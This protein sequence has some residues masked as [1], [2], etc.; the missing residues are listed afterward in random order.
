MTWFSTIPLAL[1]CLALLFV[2]G[3]LVLLALGI[4]QARYLALAP[5]LSVGMVSVAG[6]LAPRA[7][8]AWSLLPVAV[9]VAVLC[10][11]MIALR[12]IPAL[13]AGAENTEIGWRQAHRRLAVP[14]I[15]FVAGAG[16]VAYSLK[17]VFDR[18]ENISQ[19]FDNVFHLNAIQY[20]LDTKNASSLS[21]SD[22]TSGGGPAFFYPAAWHD[23]ASL[24]VQG[25]GAEIPV[26]VNVLNICIAAVVW[27]SGCMFLTRA[28]AGRRP[29]VI[30]AAGL[31][32]AGFGSFPLLLLDFGVLYP[33]FLSISLIPGVLGAVAI[34]L[35]V[36]KDSDPSRLQRYY[37]APAGSLAVALAHPN[38]VMSLLALS[39]PVILGAFVLGLL[40]RGRSP[41][42]LAIAAVSVVGLIVGGFLVVYLWQVI[43]PPLEAI[44]WGPI[45]S[46]GQAIGEIVSNSAMLR[47]PAWTV[48]I[49]MIAGLAVLIHR[50][51]SLWAVASFAAVGF[52]F[53]VVSGVSDLD[54]RLAVTGVWYNDSYRLAALLPVMAVPLA[55]IG[56]GALAE[57]CA[58]LDFGGHR[59]ELGTNKTVSSYRQP[60]IIVL[61]VFGLIGYTQMI[62]LAASV[63]SARMSYAEVPDSPLVSS[64]ELAILEKVDALVPEGATIAANPW[65]GAALAYA[66]ADRNTTSKHTLTTYTASEK[67]INSRLR[68]AASDPDV[69]NAV[70]DLNVGYVLD[71]GTQG[72]NG[73]GAGFPGL[74]ISNPTDGF[75]LLAQVGDAKL[76]EVTACR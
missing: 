28:I 2:P 45:Q 26:V 47:P 55:A 36:A 33:N 68:W 76:F 61:V 71:F 4:R 6:L 31:L 59:Q 74:E 57:K 54:F 22:M 12:F 52:L 16:L 69:C 25:T 5:S 13:R 35:G 18:P 66:L 65:T 40:K 49:L 44:T 11:L 42:A 8:M 10:A 20:I 37:L 50:R 29:L 43:R 46:E 62:P 53:V 72:V 34:F 73:G 51:Q 23:M 39:I 14:L 3:G 60:T 30:G 48:S 24:L 75:T 70:R 63:D 9:V 1:A 32:S 19:T 67:L 27:V 58:S 64:D 56:A 38:G 7:G 17:M 21:L 41:K 15:G